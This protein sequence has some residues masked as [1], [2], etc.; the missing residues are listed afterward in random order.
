MIVAHQFTTEP[1]PCAYLPERQATLEYSFAVSMAAQEYEDLMNS[2]Y[3]KFGAA[4]FKTVCSGCVACRPVRIPVER[5][6][7]DRS[8][9]RTWKKNLDLSVQIA[10]P[11]CDE[12]RLNLYNRYHE[13]QARLKGWPAQSSSREEYFLSLVENP[14][15]SAEIS[16]WEGSELRA[17]IICDLTP[18]VVSAVYHFH[19]PDHAARGL[20]TFCI[21]NC[22]QLARALKKPWVYLGFHVSGCRSME[23][24]ARFRP[25]Q[26]MDADGN[27][28]DLPA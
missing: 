9:Q 16:V 19:D 23:Y 5:F 24:K 22:I 2:G 27:W 12:Q 7:P 15:P 25:L 21:L 8:Q 10:A 28:A 20:G 26:I 3:R 13:A 14:V 1:H 6:N 11:S 4:F 17:A 18:N